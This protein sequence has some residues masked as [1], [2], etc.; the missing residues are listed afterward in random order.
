M[1]EK[2]IL[3]YDGH[4][5]LCHGFVLFVLKRESVTNFDF[6]PLQGSTFE[7]MHL[8]ERLDPLPDSIVLITK[9][10]EVLVLSS[11]AVSVFLELRQPWRFYGQVMNVI[12]LPFRDFG[13]CCVASVR[14]KIFKTPDSACPLVPV[15]LR[16]RFLP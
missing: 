10:G 8:G 4:C 12:P 11:A 14:K 1:P 9:E 2:S 3:F 15:E 5:G 6:A 16:S 7:E 13:Y